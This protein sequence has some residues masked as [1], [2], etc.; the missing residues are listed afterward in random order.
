MT[1]RKRKDRCARGHSLHDAYE[2][3][4]KDGTVNR[5]CRTCKIERARKLQTRCR[6]GH[7]MNEQNTRWDGARRRCVVC[8]R[9][10]KRARK[11][12]CVRGHEFT[13][14]TMSV[15]SRGWRKCLICRR[16]DYARRGA[17]RPKVNP[18]VVLPVPPRDVD[19]VPA[20]KD[21]PHFTSDDTTVLKQAARVCPSCPLI[22]QC[23]ERALVGKSW[24][25]YA[26]NVLNGNLSRRQRLAMEAMAT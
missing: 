11:T 21:D 7:E 23:A 9:T 26:G 16:E 1:T 10:T 15:S 20:C 25:V 18:A 3:I 2:N 8:E 12:H 19:A 22:A 13:D 24:G 14:E 5:H 17:P 6:R 4:K